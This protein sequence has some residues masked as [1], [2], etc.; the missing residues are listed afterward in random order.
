MLNGNK[1]VDDINDTM[2]LLIPKGPEPKDMT[3]FRLISLCRVI[4]KII[5]KVWANILKVILLTYISSTQSVFVPGH[6]IHENVLITHE[7]KHYLQ[8]VKN[9][10]NK[11]FV[12]RHKQ[13]L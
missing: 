4:Y 8:S 10:S 5:S 2:V 1:G 11:G 13:D 6:M 3:Q 12:A 9:G 7:M